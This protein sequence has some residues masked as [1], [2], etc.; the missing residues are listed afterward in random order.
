MTPEE[1]VRIRDRRASHTFDEVRV[2]YDGGCA[3]CDRMATCP[4]LH[5][6]LWETIAPPE[7]HYMLPRG[8]LSTKGVSLLCRGCAEKRLGRAITPNDLLPCRANVA[9]YEAFERE[10]E[11]REA[12]LQI[13][14]LEAENARLR[15]SPWE[16]HWS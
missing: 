2:V 5:D 7:H 14:K 12:R 16:G 8:R 1:Y 9:E 13:E 3:D 6:E 10:R 11:L 15:R 4:M